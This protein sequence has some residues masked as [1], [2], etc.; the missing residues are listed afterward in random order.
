MYF[1]SLYG[2]EENTVLTNEKK[3]SQEEFVRMC[4][5]IHSNMEYCYTGEIVK[6]LI[7]YYGFKEIKYT[8]SFFVDEDI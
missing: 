3:I 7:K 8:S 5:E 2:F 1:Y 6:Y 4:K